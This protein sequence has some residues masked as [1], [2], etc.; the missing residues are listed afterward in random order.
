ML[1][2]DSRDLGGI[3]KVA[4]PF[5]PFLARAQV[6][7]GALALRLRGAREL[8][9]ELLNEL[10]RMTGD[11]DPA[12]D[13]FVLAGSP[14]HDRRLD[15]LD[16]LMRQVAAFMRRIDVGMEQTQPLAPANPR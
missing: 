3:P 4:P 2:H 10:R 16:V 14:P 12:G 9:A 15:E 1:L 6:F 7:E 13:R 11:R 8:R 5:E